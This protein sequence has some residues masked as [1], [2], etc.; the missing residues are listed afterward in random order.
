MKPEQLKI[1]DTLLFHSQPKDEFGR[2]VSYGIQHLTQSKYNHVGTYIG[3]GIVI[4]ALSE[5]YKKQTIQ[6]AV[7]KDVDTVSIYR[8]HCD[9]DEL[10]PTQQQGLVK[11]CNDHEGVP[12]DFADILMLALIMEVN[13]TSWTSGALRTTLSLGLGIT[14]TI[15]MGYI[16]AYQAIAELLMGNALN[17]NNGMLICSC[18]G[19]QALTVGAGVTVDLLN[20]D[21][22][23]N[24]YKLNGNISDRF[25]A[26][27]S[28]DLLETP[29]AFITPR[30]IA[31]SPDLT[32]LDTLE[33]V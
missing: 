26:V 29:V 18:A 22:R 7:V 23:E 25:K 28:K 17:T 10:T 20:S 16:K 4:G 9:R 13:D 19:Y 30:D 15:I 11:W 14:D 8:Y 27:N 1:G 33:I 24:F 3:N 6:D 21:A 12:Y 31:E 2:I 32:F 5:G